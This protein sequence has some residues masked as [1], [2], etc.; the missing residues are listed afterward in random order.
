[1]RLKVV[2]EGFDDS[3]VPAAVRSDVL[4]LLNYRS[5]VFGRPFTYALDELLRGTS[6][7]SVG[8]RELMAAFVSH[9]NECPFCAGSH[10]EFAS[11]ALGDEGP[12]TVALNDLESAPLSAPLRAAC[13]LLAKLTREPENLGPDDIAATR[14][15]GASEQA[16]SDA[17]HIGALFNMISR[18]ANA[19]DFEPKDDYGGDQWLVDAAFEETRYTAALEFSGPDPP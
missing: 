10:A 1:M 2:D 5:D 8:E 12:V 3:A 16:I 19:L 15:S 6:D 17:I 14:R 4:K 9:Q 18:C 7:W 13:R 11:I